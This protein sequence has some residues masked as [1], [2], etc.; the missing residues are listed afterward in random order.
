VPDGVPE[1]AR[2]GFGL[3]G[4]RHFFPDPFATHLLDSGC[5]IKPVQELL[6]LKDVILFRFQDEPYCGRLAAWPDHEKST[7]NW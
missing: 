3:F 6:G 1:I 7:T 2:A 4:K 5:D